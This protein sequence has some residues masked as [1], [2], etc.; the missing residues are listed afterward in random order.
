MIVPVLARPTQFDPNMVVVQ[1][2][3]R[4]R[5]YWMKRD[6]LRSVFLADID[7]MYAYHVLVVAD[8]PHKDADPITNLL[9]G[10]PGLTCHLVTK[11]GTGYT[12]EDEATKE[13]LALW[14]LP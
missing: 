13:I 14:N 10:I 8:D 5:S 11:T 9:S 6:V 12:A 2:D 3:S 4:K 1:Y 7:P